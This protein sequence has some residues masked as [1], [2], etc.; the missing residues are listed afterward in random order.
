MGSR[1]QGSLLLKLL[2]PLSDVPEKEHRSRLTPS[3][4]PG[5]QT[6][7]VSGT[8]LVDLSLAPSLR[9]LRSLLAA[10]WTPGAPAGQRNHSP[11][12]CRDLGPLSWMPCYEHHGISAERHEMGEGAREATHQQMGA[13]TA[14]E[15]PDVEK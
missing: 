8:S 13:R 7:A 11:E 14:T 6:S 15:R 1:A 2:K 5:P 3:R 12:G 9:A 4:V 10:R